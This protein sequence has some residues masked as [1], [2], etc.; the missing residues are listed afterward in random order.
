MVVG[1]QLRL[2]TKNITGTN[3]HLYIAY[4]WLRAY[5]GYH[6]ELKLNIKAGKLMEL[7]DEMG[8]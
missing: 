1:A 6:P 7:E 5:F 2:S 4:C 8:I 3:M